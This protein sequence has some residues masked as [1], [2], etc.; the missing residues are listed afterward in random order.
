MDI[1]EILLTENPS[2]SILDL[3]HSGE[4]IK[5]LPELSALDINVN[6]HKNNFYHTLKVLDN[7]IEAN[8]N[9]NMRILALLH[10]IGKVHTRKLINNE[11]TFHNHEEIGATLVPAILQRLD[12]N[13]NVNYFVRMV[14]FHGRLKLID[15]VTDSAIRRLDKEIGDDII[16]DL[17]EFCKYDNSTSKPEKLKRI[18]NGLDDIKNRIIEVRTKDKEASWRSPLTGDIIMEIL[19]IPQGRLVGEIKKEYDEKFKNN[20]ISLD[21]AIIEIKQKFSKLNI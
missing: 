18:C 14:K 20:V 17:I 6:G 21:D 4:L 3:H 15:D 8:A 1:I 12:I 13:D 9:F 5:I 19:N 10:D 16:F 11:Y 2:K 7:V